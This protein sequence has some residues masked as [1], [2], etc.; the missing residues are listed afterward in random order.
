MFL[1]RLYASYQRS[2]LILVLICSFY[3][4]QILFG[5]TTA[6]LVLLSLKVVERPPGI[7]LPGC[8]VV[9]PQQDQLS[10][11][12]WAVAMFTTC[13]YFVLILN[14]FTY[15]VSL[16]RESRKA[17]QVS[18]FDLPTISPLIYSF[19]RD[20]AFYFFLVFAGNMMNLIFQI[21]F[22]GRPL[23]SI[24][25]FWLAAIYAVSASRLCLNTRESLRH[26]SGGGD[27]D[28]CWFDD[29]ELH[30]RPSTARTRHRIRDVLPLAP[31]QDS[32][33]LGVTFAQSVSLQRSNT[34]ESDRKLQVGREPHTPLSMETR[35]SGDSY[36]LIAVAPW[37]VL[38][39]PAESL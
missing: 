15:N 35:Y 11:A 33:S 17:S 36:G 2:K 19:L 21:L 3:A 8:L 23:L 14:K 30:D 9:P 39:R 34:F 32:K 20:S 13:V 38:D 16:R 4:I 5:T 22:P 7:P 27:S 25:F 6:T 26:G 31:P 28:T 18:L 1:M 24:G 12:A 37:I 10:T 29:I